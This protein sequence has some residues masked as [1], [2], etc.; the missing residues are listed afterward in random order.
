[1]LSCT[2]TELASQSILKIIG[3]EKV[4]GKIKEIHDNKK[5]RSDIG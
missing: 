4:K 1:M 3:L 2:T 5:Y